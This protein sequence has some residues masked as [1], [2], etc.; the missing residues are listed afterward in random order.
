MNEEEFHSFKVEDREVAEV[1][2]GELQQAMIQEVGGAEN[3]VVSVDSDEEEFHGYEF[4]KRQQRYVIENFN[5]L[6]Y[7]R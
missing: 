2:S 3:D 6:Q 1:C 4:E 7:R 5:R